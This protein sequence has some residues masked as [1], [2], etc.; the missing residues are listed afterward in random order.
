MLST[1]ITRQARQQEWDT[2]C[3]IDMNNGFPL[4]I[5]YNLKNKIIKTLKAKN[6]PTQTQRKKWI[7]FTY[8]NP[9]IHK[10][11]NLFKRTDLDVAFRTCNN[12]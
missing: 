8:H 10:V 5:I 12:M 7:T 1:P 6:T 11:T 2:I 4:Q 9:L 3:T